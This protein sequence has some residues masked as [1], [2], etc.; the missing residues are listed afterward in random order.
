MQEL[1]ERALVAVI[2]K[3]KTVHLRDLK[4]RMGPTLLEEFARDEPQPGPVR[5]LLDAIE[6]R[7]AAKGKVKGERRIF[8]SLCSGVTCDEF[9]M[10]RPHV[11][12]LSRKPMY[13]VGGSPLSVDEEIKRAAFLGKLRE[14]VLMFFQGAFSGGREP[15]G[16]RPPR[17]ISRRASA[18]VSSASAR[19]SR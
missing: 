1:V 10:A 15:R 5:A 19:P 12:D 13:A 4:T 9:L 16:N 3:A 11:F 18:Q 2:A 8:P 17:D 6:A 7:G 14:Q